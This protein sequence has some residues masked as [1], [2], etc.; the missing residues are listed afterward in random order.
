[1]KRGIWALAVLAGLE[2]AACAG[3]ERPSRPPTLTVQSNLVEVPTLVTTK[4]GEVVF[5]LSAKNFVLTDDGAPQTVRV[6]ADTDSQPLAL[7]IVVETGGVGVSHREDYQRLGAILEALVGGVEHRVAVIGFDSTPELLVPFTSDTEEAA[8]ELD[9]LPRGDQKAGILDAL[10]FAV[11]ELRGEPADYRRAILL[12]SETIDQGSKTTLTEA[13]R[14]ISD[15]NTAMYSFAFSSTRAAVTHEAA[16]FNRPG[17]PGPA[18]GCFSRDGADAE[19]KGHY[20][21][22]VLDCISDLAP[23]L[24]LATMAFVAARDGLRK[25]T[26]ESVA[27]LTGGEYVHFKNAKDLRTGLIALSNDVPNAYVLSF[28]PTTPTEGLHA[29]HV[30]VT[31]RPDLVVRARTEY[32]MEQSPAPAAQP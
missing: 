3:Q 30:E 13:L 1:V 24:R 11:D 12:L 8:Q 32:W 28:R 14:Q 4:K 23:P 22:Q 27:R 9:H 29:L 31:G 20:S 5:G 15:T 26:A 6:E 19:Y 17:E 21:K 18:H 10:A 7:A 2:C 25:N 16:K